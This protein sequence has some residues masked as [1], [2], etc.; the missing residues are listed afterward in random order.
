[1]KPRGLHQ[2]FYR[3][4][5]L[6][7]I[8]SAAALPASAVT[9]DFTITGTAVTVVQGA[10]TGNT[11]TI[12]V[13]PVGGFTGSV[14]LAAAVTSSPANAVVPPTLSFG[15]TSP[16]TITGTTAG[17]ATLII[18]TTAQSSPGC[19]NTAADSRSFLSYTAGGAA[20][21]CILLLGIPARRQIW[22]TSLGMLFLLVALTSGT[23]AC[24]GQQQMIACP[25]VI[26][27]G[28][29]PGTY[30]VTVTGTSTSTTT[31][32]AVTLTVTAQVVGGS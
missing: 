4:A 30:T 6:A 20:L 12:T 29:T 3:S 28:T 25:A 19:T 18:S 21:A 17:T 2:L 10:T 14:A 27:A 22:R 1:M 13:T 26:R 8:V 11:S 31:T 24:S 32:G 23:L 5:I 16:V 15:S 7:V 9:P